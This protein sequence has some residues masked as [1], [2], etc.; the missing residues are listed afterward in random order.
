MEKEVSILQELL[1]TMSNYILLAK[2]TLADSVENEQLQI[3]T[4][5]SSSD[6]QVSSLPTHYLND[7]LA[8][9]LSSSRK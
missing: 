1:F 3:C 2:S 9:D 5:L 4:Q 6:A 8:K 7:A